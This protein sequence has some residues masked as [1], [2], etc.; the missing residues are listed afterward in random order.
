MKT[1]SIDKEIQRLVNDMKA[2]ARTIRWL[3]SRKA[4]LER[5]EVDPDSIQVYGE[6]NLDFNNL[7]HQDVI[8]VVRAF[9]GKWKKVPHGNDRVDYQQE[10]DGVRVRCYAGAP[11]PNCRIVEVEEVIPARVI[12]EQRI[13]VKKMICKGDGSEP[14]AEAIAF[15]QPK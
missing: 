13:K 4:I 1:E 12:P 11:P 7:S 2:K 10:I 6:S 5:I 9:G 8:K 15:T 14:V 3:R